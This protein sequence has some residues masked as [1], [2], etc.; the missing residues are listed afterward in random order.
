MAYDKNAARKHRR[1][2]KKEI[3]FLNSVQSNRSA[4]A[5]IRPKGRAPRGQGGEYAARRSIAGRMD[6][7]DIQVATLDRKLASSRGLA[8]HRR[9]D[10]AAVARRQLLKKARSDSM[11]VLD[12]GADW[13]F[14]REMVNIIIGAAT[15]QYQN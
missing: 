2:I 12:T 7:L 14:K 3:D 11:K 5:A 10:T 4:G 13:T 9:R 15:A 8:K 6:T 1:Q